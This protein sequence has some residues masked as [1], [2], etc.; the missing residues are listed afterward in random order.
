MAGV[1]KQL[2]QAARAWLGGLVDLLLPDVCAACGAAPVAAEGLCG[3]CN[4]ELLSLVSLPFCPRCSSTLGPNVPAREDGCGECPTTLPRFDRVFR[5]G[6][7]TGCLRQTIRDLKYHRRQRLRRRLTD[8]LAGRITA[9]WDGPAFDVVLAVP[10]HWRRRLARGFDHARSIASRLAA[11]LHLPLGGELL[12]TRN[13]PPQTH[14][15][16]TRRIENV[17]RAFAVR[18]AATVQGAAVLLVDDVTTTGATADEAARTLFDAGAAHVALAVFAK[19][20]SPR[21]YA[22]VWE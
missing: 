21:A 4:V 3:R 16:R 2:T 11:T 20:E 10:M 6:P 9:G 7:Y 1:R 22:H 17:R 13:T 19:A 8:L 18:G 5:L 14:L 15:S 12:R